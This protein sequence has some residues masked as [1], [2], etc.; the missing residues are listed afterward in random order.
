MQVNTYTAHHDRRHQLS[1]FNDAAS[2]SR[3]TDSLLSRHHLVQSC[4]FM[5][6]TLLIARLVSYPKLLTNTKQ[7]PTQLT[8]L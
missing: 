7:T 1:E 3:R 5:R 6:A 4:S 8:H 2:P